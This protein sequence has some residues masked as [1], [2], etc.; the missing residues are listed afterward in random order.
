MDPGVTIVNPTEISVMYGYVTWRMTTE[1]SVMYG[2]EGVNGE[3]EQFY[4]TNVYMLLLCKYILFI[5]R[6]KLW[7]SIY[8]RVIP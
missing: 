4:L 8:F 2:G 5:S 3:V 6:W 7:S 1:I